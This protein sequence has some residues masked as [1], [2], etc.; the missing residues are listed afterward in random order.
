MVSGDTNKVLEILTNNPENI[1]FYNL[2][3]QSAPGFAL[4]HKLFNMYQIL[5]SKNIIFG[6]HEDFSAIKDALKESERKELREIHYKESKFLPDNHMNILISNSR[7]GHE[8]TK[9]ASK[10]GVIQEAFQILNE[11]QFIQ[12]IL[13]IVAASRNFRIIFDFNR[14]SV[15]VVDPTSNSSSRG[16][17]YLT[18]RIYIGAKQLLSPN[19]KHDALGTLAHELCHYAMLLVYKNNAKPYNG[20]DSKAAIE[21]EDVSK[22]CLEN[23]DIEEIIGCVYKYYDSNKHHAELIVRVPHLIMLYL[24]NSDKFDEIKNIFGKLFEYFEKKVIPDCKEA[25]PMIENEAESEAEEKAIKIIKL[26]V[27]SVFVLILSVIGIIAGILI[28]KSVLDKPNFN[29]TNLSN[30]QKILVQNAPVYYKNVKI[31]FYDL[32]PSNSTIYEKLTSDHISMMLN[33]DP[34]NFND[35][36]LYYLNN[37]IVHNWT[38]LCINLKTKFLN[39][40]FTFQNESIMFQNLHE[41]NPMPFIH[42]NSS[43]I[44]DV[45]D[46]KTIEI[47]KM[48]KSKSKFFLERKIFDENIFEIFFSYMQVVDGRQLVP[49]CF[50]NRFKK[51]KVTFEQYYEMFTAVNLT[52]Q[53][54]EIN[55]I[56]Q[57]DNFKSCQLTNFELRLGIDVVDSLFTHKSFQFDFD[58]VFKIANETKI[59]ILSSEAGAGKTATFENFAVRLKKKFPTRWVSYIDLKDYKHFYDVIQN[60]Q[61][62]KNM[63]ET[64]FTLSSENEFEKKIFESSFK[65][66][67]LILLWNGFDEISPDYNKAV[68]SILNIINGNSENIQFI[69]TRPLYSEQL[70][71]NFSVKSYTLVP[72]DEVKQEE[73]LNEFFKAEKI[74]PDD[75][76]DHI[77]MVQYI[78][79]SLKVEENINT[80]LMLGMIADLIANDAEIYESENIYLYEIYQKFVDKKIQ[81]WEENSEFAKKF[82]KSLLNKNSGFSMKKIYQKYAMKIEFQSMFNNDNYLS[83]LKLKIMRLKS[84]TELTSDEISRMGILYINEPKQLKFAHK[85]FIDFFIAQYFIENIY[86]AYDEPSYEEADLRLQIYYKLFSNDGSFVST[87]VKSFLKTK[88]ANENENFD[89]MISKL[90]TTKF[91]DI[92]FNHFRV[93]NSFKFHF[94]FFKKSK[95]VLSCLLHVDDSSTF[96]TFTYNYGNFPDMANLHALRNDLKNLSENALSK[97]DFDKF[98]IGK[99][100]KGINLFSTYCFI[101][102][103]NFTKMF[104]IVHDEFP[105]PPAILANNNASEVVKLIAQNLTTEEVRQLFITKTSPIH[106][107]DVELYFDEYFLQFLESSLNQ[108]DQKCWIKNIFDKIPLFYS[109]SSDDNFL[110]KKINQHFDDTEI[111]E[112]FKNST[113]L[114][115]NAAFDFSTFNNSWNFLVNH[116]NRNQQKLI[117][118]QNFQI[119]CHLEPSDYLPLSMCYFF[120]S[121]NILQSSLFTGLI[122]KNN[123]EPFNNIKNIYGSYFENWEIQKIIFNSNDFLSFLI[124]NQKI[125]MCKIFVDY[126]KEIFNGNEALLKNFIF[127]KIEPTNFDI[128]ELLKDYAFIEDKLKLF[129]DLFV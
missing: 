65:S 79:E 1:H 120:P 9:R 118:Q 124:I 48:I 82:L 50:Y 17:F 76:E 64:I 45:L 12:I 68:L 18:G 90:L 106:S 107:F 21:F 24:N 31:K 7:L 115:V 105:L 41:S 78:V 83:F 99:N 53:F 55:E 56:K 27:F 39:S 117:L 114:H 51:T 44:V 5:I 49:G 94:D 15:E 100:Q 2:E 25:L 11:N 42:L 34:L 35:P 74:D 89:P 73:F 69:C 59:F 8:T 10:Y 121:L 84:P 127:Q 67:N 112:L 52:E 125:D 46:G 104:K 91:R 28:T 38:N 75:I 36:H 4:K 72:F 123:S 126:L 33:N 23:L 62:V 63:F 116:T 97:N 70:R 60:F 96:Y 87:F 92:F 103:S 101:K 61:D 88:K 119:E 43:Q 54:Q 80:P 122:S 26:K 32:F 47:H 71:Q 129:S 113:V 16:L 86:N 77:E 57:N 111:F 58:Q 95:Q 128:F 3:N 13:L 108:V 109:G 14:D 93:S 98:I 20:N 40:N 81:I 29:F 37:L 22:Y 85:T 19:N 30:E 102:F 110:Y 66:G 6:P